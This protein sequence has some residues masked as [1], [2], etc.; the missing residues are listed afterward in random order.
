MEY[1]FSIFWLLYL[2]DIVNSYKVNLMNNDLFKF[3]DGSSINHLNQSL[4]V[5][6]LN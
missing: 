1:K 5:N 3:L 6:D 4:R 2:I